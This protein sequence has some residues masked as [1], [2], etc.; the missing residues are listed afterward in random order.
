MMEEEL[1]EA[2]DAVVS[3]ALGAVTAAWL[4]FASPPRILQLCPV[5]RIPQPPPARPRRARCHS[6]IKTL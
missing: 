4:Q 6:A 1:Y 2:M 5:T 3:V